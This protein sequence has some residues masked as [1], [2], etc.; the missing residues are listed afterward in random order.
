[1]EQVLINLYLNAMQAMPGGGES[2]PSFWTIPFWRSGSRLQESGP[3]VMS[4]CPSRDTGVGMDEKTRARIFDPFF[5]TKKMG[6]GTGLGLAMVYGIIR[7]H[8]GMIDVVSEVGHGST[9]TICL[10]ASDQKPVIAEKKESEAF[11]RGTET[12]LLVD[13]EK[14]ILKVAQ[15]LLEAMGYR[16]LSVGSGQAAIAAYLEKR[17]QIDLII[18]D[19]VMPGIS[20]GETF[21]RLREIDPDVKVLLASGYSV[22][23]EAQK[24]LDRGCSGFIQ[25]PFQTGS[26]SRKIREVLDGQPQQP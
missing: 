13:D 26:L 18:L 4:G 21:D 22:E 1:M 6:R 11:I 7:G 2:S 19:M 20:G 9:F 3:A 25:K 10:P 17:G 24:I 14:T 5:T 8:D 15:G 23:G 12:V 16:V